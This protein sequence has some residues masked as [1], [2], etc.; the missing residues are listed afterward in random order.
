MAGIKPYVKEVKHRNS[1]AALSDPTEII[2]QERGDLSLL[3]LED[4]SI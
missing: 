1:A 4:L 2:Y 3:S